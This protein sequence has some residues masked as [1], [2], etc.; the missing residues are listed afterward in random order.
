[1]AP[2]YKHFYR[3]RTVL[4]ACFLCFFLLPAAGQAANGLYT[5]EGVSVDVTAANALEAR[6][7][8]F[9]QAQQEA[10]RQLA[11][12]MLP[13]QDAAALTLPDDSVISTLV[14]D[15][16]VTQEQ[17]SAVRYIGTYIFRFKERAVNQYFGQAGAAYTAI[18]SPPLLVL[19]FYQPPGSAPI[20]WS[21]D[22]PWRAAWGRAESR[23]ALVPLVV[24]LGDLQDV[25]D[26][27]DA[28][29]FT[30]AN[31]S[32][33]RLLR[34]YGAAEAV[35]A[36]AAP[37]RALAGDSAPPPGMTL[38][39][40]IFRTDRAA[41]EQVR[42]VAVTAA[43]DMTLPALMDMAA[44]RVQQELQQDWK[45]KVAATSSALNAFPARVNFTTPQEWTETRRALE[46]V[47]GMSAVALK[48]LSPQFA[49]VDL[50]FQGD[51]ER[52]RLALQQADITISAA[53]MPETP[54]AMPV[55]ELYLNRLAPAGGQDGYIN[56]F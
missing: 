40:D 3:C 37:G 31:E 27:G 22:N 2:F 15:F 53:A 52:L 8:A 7:K 33:A 54:D 36:V 46:R 20:L 32:M 45:Q 13:A 11:G 55:Y 18:E 6:D 4:Y 16:E 42:Q 35:L 34:R 23:T 21:Q 38:T 51:E 56:R 39:V 19:P 12:R 43:P 50:M 25:Q 28:D 5:V 47:S 30:Y 10:F 1:M 29:A 24:P 44:Q 49:R 41:P 9:V 17:L 48:S 14:Q 26:I